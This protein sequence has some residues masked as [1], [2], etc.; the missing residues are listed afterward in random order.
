MEEL[1]IKTLN[2]FEK[3]LGITA[4]LETVAKNI[5]IKTGG[6]T[7]KAV[8]EADILNAVK[9]LEAK[10]R[11][12]SYPIEREIVDRDFISYTRTNGDVRQNLFMRLQVKYRFVNID[13]PEE[14]IDITSYGDGIDAGDKGCGKAMTY[15]DKY[16]LMK[17]YKIATGED[18]DN[19]ASGKITPP[20]T[21]QPAT[22]KQTSTKSQKTAPAVSQYKQLSDLLKTVQGWDLN[23][24]KDWIVNRCGKDLRV[25]DLSADVFVELVKTVKETG[26][27][28]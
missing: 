10:Y 25:N 6:E 1:N 22:S 24:V 19:E 28:Q 5:T 7:Y 18:P 12:Y 17:A 4:E 27:E 8:G 15:A 11:V 9:P 21:T 13:K 16:A 2:I 26:N 3:L 23:R 20:Q 14:Y